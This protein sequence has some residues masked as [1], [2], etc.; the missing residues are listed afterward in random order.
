MLDFIQ[1]FPL[2]CII[3]TLFSGV[4]CSVLSARAARN[5]CLMVVSADGVLNA[6]VLVYT[7]RMGDSFTYMMGHFPAPWGNEIR[8]GVLE[9]M[10]AMVFSIVMLLSLLGGMKHIFE[11]VESTKVNLYFLMM[12]LLF[13]SMLCLIYTNDL[14]TGYV[15]V[16]INTIAAC[17]IVMARKGNQTLVATMRYLCL[18]LLGSGM[19]L[20]GICILY[21]ITGHLLMVSLHGTIEQLASSGQYAQPLEVVIVLF[22]VGLATK[23][24]LFPFHSWLPD[25]HGSSTSAS[26]AIL[27]GLVLKGYIILLIKIVYRVLGTDVF[28]SSKAINVLFFFGCCAMI[29]GSLHAMTEKDL[30]RMIAYSSVAQ[31]GYIFMGIGQQKVFTAARSRAPQR[32]GRHSLRGRCVVHDWHSDVCRIYHQI[33]PGGRSHSVGHKKTDHRADGSGCFHTAERHVLCSCH[34]GSFLTGGGQ[35]AGGGQIHPDLR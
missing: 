27:S 4:L 20:M 2:F 30:K 1:N 29:V 28:N 7:I 12:N 31:I 9:A 17:A 21:D 33:L 11:D 19:F 32:T 13:V 18:S 16:E 26:S 35:F 10:L 14:F 3:M 5:C 8:V 24:A 6:A 23:S 22:C 34:H 15:F 25:A